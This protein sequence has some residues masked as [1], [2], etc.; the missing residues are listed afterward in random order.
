VLVLLPPSETKAPGGA[1]PAVDLDTLLWPEL[2][3]T[4][5]TLLDALAALS[6]DLPT[7]RA[8]LKVAAGKDDDIRG[9][10]RVRAASTRKALDRYTGVLY[11]ALD[12]PSMSRAE[13]SRAEARIVVTS[14]LFGAVR[15]G[16]AIPAYRLSAGS[17]LPGLGTVAPLW[18][19][20]A[21]S[22]F[23]GLDAPV[24]DLRSG[25]Y[26]AFGAV[27]GAVTVR[28]VSR[29]PDGRLAVVSHFNKATKGRL[30][31]LVA[32]APRPVASLRAVLRLARNAGFAIEQTG[33]GSA[34][35]I[36]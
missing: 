10:A 27:P 33:P 9:N 30:A 19:Q 34:Q 16:D 11:D 3:D 4:R 2:R 17:T 18:R 7:A 13:R 20:A 32:T 6:R 21:G 23:R 35:I 28:V 1:G 24:L 22:L 5:S 8:A 15:A 12:A 31:R 14:A 26:A 29:Q 25:A 36:T